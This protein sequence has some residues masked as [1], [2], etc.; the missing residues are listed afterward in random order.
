MAL[1]HLRSSTANKRPIPTVMSAGQLAINTNEGSPGLFFKNSNGDL[2]KVGPVH[3][4]TSAPNST[5]DSLAA[6]ALVTGTVYQVLTVGNSDFTLVGASANT[7]GTVFT[8][9]GTTT[10]TG[11]VSGQQGNEKGEQWLDTTGSAFDLKIYDGNAWR[12]QAGEFVNVTGDTMTGAFG[13]VA[14]TASAP[15]VFFSGD[16]NTGL[17]SPG[18]DSVAVTTGGTQ[19]VVV[20]SSGNVGI[21]NSNPSDYY[22]QSNDLVVG[23]TSGNRGISVVS[24]TT[25]TGSLV[26]ADGTGNFE[27]RKGQIVYDHST[28]SLE[29]FTDQTERLRIDSSGNVGIGTI[30]PATLLH[31]ETGHAKQTLK[32]T[33]TNTA[34]SIIFDTTNVTTADFL[35]GQIAGKWNGTDVAYINFEAGSDTTNKDDGLI[36]FATS[37]AS[38]SPTEQMRIDSSGNV[39]VGLTGPAAKLDVRG[40]VSA[41]SGTPYKYLYATDGS[42]RVTGSESAVDICSTDSGAHAS[43]I[44][45]RG[46]QKGYALVNNTSNDSLDLKSFTASAD[47]FTV[48]GT[49]GAGT[50]AHVNIASITKAGN[51]GIGTTSPSVPL[52]VSSSSDHSDIAIFHAGGGTPDRGL[53]ISTFS[54]TNANAG[55]KFDAQTNTGAFKFSIGGTDRL[56]IDSSG[57]LLVGSTSNFASANCDL[58]QVG[59]TSTSATGLTIGSSTQG[60]IAFADSGNQRAGL[61]HYQ[62]TDNSLR[63]MTNGAAN[64]H[65]RIDS[66]GNVGIG[67]TANGSNAKLEVR[68]TTGAINSAT[69]RV[70]G[71]LTDTGAANTGS[72]LLFAGNIGTGERDF[73][74]VFA[75]KENGTSG[76]TSSYLAFGTRINGGS[77]AE[78]M[79][80][81]SSGNVK[82]IGSG[83]VAV[84]KIELHA[85]GNIDIAGGNTGSSTGSAG[86]TFNANGLISV[87]RSDSASSIFAGYAVNGTSPVINL[88]ADGSASFGGDLSIEN[89]SYIRVRTTG[90]DTSTAIQLGPDGSASFAGSIDLPTVNTFIRGGGHDVLQVDATRTYFYGGSN[91]VQ[92]RKADNSAP[93]VT[94]DDY[95]NSTF[96]GTVQSKNSTNIAELASGANTGFRLLQNGSTANVVMGWDGSATFANRVNAGNNTL[97]ELA[98]KAFNNSSSSP[99]LFCQNFNSSGDVFLASNA[100]NT[101]VARIGVDGSATLS[102]QITVN[103]TGGKAYE[104]YYNG[105]KVFQLDA[106]GVLKIGGTPASAPNIQFNVNGSATFASFVEVTRDTG[107]QTAF[108]SYLSGST[109]S[110]FK[111]TANGTVTAAGSIASGDINSNADASIYLNDGRIQAYRSS[112]SGASTSAVFLGGIK[113]G[114][115]VSVTSEIYANGSATFA[116]NVQSNGTLIANRT[117][118]SSKVFSGTL[119]GAENVQIKAGGGATFADR[120]DTGSLTVDS[121]LTP[122]TGES[123]EFFYNSGG[124]IQAYDRINAAW[125][126]LRIKSSNYEIGLDGSASFAGTI[127]VNYPAN[128]SSSDYF[129]NGTSMYLGSPVSTFSV[130]TDG[131]AT[132]A[133]TVTSGTTSTGCQLFSN[134]SAIGR[135][136]GTQKWYL[137]NN[138]NVVFA[139][140]VTASNVSD[141]RFKENITDANPQLADAVALGSQLKNFDWND[142]APLNEEQRARRFLG[143]VAQEAEKVCPG[144]TYTVPRTKQGAE[145]TPEVVVP[146]VYETRTVPAVLDDKGEVVEAETTEQVLVTE[147]QVTPATYEELDDSYKAINHDILIMKLL[148]AVAELS[149]KVA[150]LEAG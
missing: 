85:S 35:L 21:V 103:K 4:G 60:Q 138:G 142:D 120:V 122:T 92:I 98:V 27:N 44:L 99:S 123:I 134:G 69:L 28:N 40:G 53:K 129:L 146:A 2:V 71:G 68:S 66:S 88:K 19:R 26:F 84:P 47:A 95:G 80:I 139:G 57:R 22:P 136:S 56:Q 90:D 23:T 105:T 25:G 113:T 89:S 10:G 112:S 62:H 119:N 143:L 55:V 45:I 31:L 74:S 12:S 104:Q 34:S 54:N 116:D 11:T 132:F 6:T 101:T 52:T 135:L 59:N 83:T 110:T 141:A 16:T 63:F 140:S 1:Q 82:V 91:G 8:A 5:P 75:G 9:T 130:A 13:V 39:G 100:S 24:A 20:D 144:L 128:S 150:A 148:G 94:V 131:S 96:S 37:A 87:R 65:L 86:A 70:N 64:E 137:N 127:T 107:N 67:S 51:V 50:S 48:H 41:I 145:L 79:R 33:N 30:S 118:A 36:S 32:S 58:L 76:N 3:I 102:G 14:G 147:E 46:L 49:S 43:S 124:Y 149:A 111:V 38:G 133:N 7:V 114:S 121:N 108:A 17:L 106:D 73:A 93:I 77:V 115:G 42:I 72:T 78:K 81:D 109:D 126:P 18:S 117:N 97:D 15:G 61:I 125:K 29:L